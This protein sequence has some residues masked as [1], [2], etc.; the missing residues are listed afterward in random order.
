[1]MKSSNAAMSAVRWNDTQSAITELATA[2][3]NRSVCAQHAVIARVALDDRGMTAVRCEREPFELP[4]RLVERPGTPAP[5]VQPSDRGA[6]PARSAG[7]LGRQRNDGAVAV[8]VHLPDASPGRADL[9][10]LAGGEVD[11]EQA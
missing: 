1:M 11:E 4:G 3:A 6:V 9:V 8:P 7:L 5:E 2:A 10:D